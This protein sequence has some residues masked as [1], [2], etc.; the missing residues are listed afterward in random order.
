MI[1]ITKNLDS[2]FYSVYRPIIV[3]GYDTDADTAFLRGELL[4]ETPMW[5]G[6][7]VSTGIMMNG[8]E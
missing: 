6:T 5:S 7:Y 1:N 8:Y 2:A 3:T 4:I